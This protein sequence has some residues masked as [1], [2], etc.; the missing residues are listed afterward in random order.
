METGYS[1]KEGSYG[2]QG[3]GDYRAWGL[4]TQKCQN[5]KLKRH[6]CQ[7]D[8]DKGGP[9][10]SSF[11]LHGEGEFIAASRPSQAT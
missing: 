6:R 8:Q 11:S 4:L 7:C 2:L 3:L 1:R 5:K 10:G 9:Q